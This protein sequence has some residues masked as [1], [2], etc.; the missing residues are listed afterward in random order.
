MLVEHFLTQVAMRD[1]RDVKAFD[2]E[3]IDLL[4]RYP[5]PG[6]VRE[7]QNICERAAVMTPSCVIEAGLIQPWLTSPTQDADDAMSFAGNSSRKL[8]D[9]E[10]DE[11]VRALGRY[12]GNRQQTAEALGIGVR[13]LGLKL[14]KWKDDNLVAQTL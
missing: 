6:N 10:R 9:I 1:G 12:N 8:S 14:K 11:I 13:T 4:Q 3:A 2:A 5:W 7:L